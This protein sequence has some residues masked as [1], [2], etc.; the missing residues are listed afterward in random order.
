MRTAGVGKSREG[1]ID[2]LYVA[3]NA[4]WI[5]GLS[6]VLASLSYASWWGQMHGVRLGA[7]LGRRDCVVP[8]NL[9]LLLFCASLAW[10]ATRWWERGLWVLLALAF[11]WQAASA[12]RRA[13]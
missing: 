4:L 5:F 2:W 12:P 8:T 7:A 9:G 3:R 13:D 6:I 11:A 1:M 10:G